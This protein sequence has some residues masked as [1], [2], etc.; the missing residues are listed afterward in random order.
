MVNE[1][2]IRERVA[3]YLI[4]EQ[5]F[6]MF[7]DWLMEQSHNM[8]QDSSQDAQELVGDIDLHIYEYLDGNID[9]ER[10]KSALRPFVEQYE[11][12]VSF[13]DLPASPSRNKHSQARI[14]SIQ[15]QFLLVS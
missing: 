13:R 2:Q 5:E 1:S 8:H 4:G 7:H 3:S 15:A 14:I 9:E 6:E 10:L 12:H 11:A